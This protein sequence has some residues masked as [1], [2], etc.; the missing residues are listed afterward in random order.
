MGFFSK[1]FSS[2]RNRVAAQMARLADAARMA[3]A[4]MLM[5][6]MGM[7]NA[8]NQ[9]KQ[10]SIA[11]RAGAQGSLLFGK[12]LDPGHRFLNL[13]KERD[14]AFAWLELQPLFKKL[15]VQTLRVDNTVAFALTGEAP[16]P[17][18]GIATL[19]RY[20]AQFRDGPNPVSYQSL[21]SEVIHSMP[22]QLQ[23]AMVAWL[24]DNR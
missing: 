24:Q 15:V 23:S 18:I 19:E 22:S 16:M 2:R 7:S 9:A 17:V 1:L 13:E 12:P 3:T 6:D 21:V 5:H 4:L 14:E 10:E 11:N 20:G 8:N